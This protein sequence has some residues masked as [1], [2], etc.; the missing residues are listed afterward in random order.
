MIELR[1]SGE[2]YEYDVRGLLMAF[3]P[4]E[5]IEKK[6]YSCEYPLFDVLCTK[7]KGWE[8]SES[9]SVPPGAWRRQLLVEC[10]Q[11]QIR[12]TLHCRDEAGVSGI[13]RSFSGT[14][15]VEGA[16]RSAAKCALKR[17]L[18]G[19]LREDTHRELPWGTLTGIRPTKIAMGFLE[20]GR[21][22]AEIAA[23]MQKEYLVSPEKTALSLEIAEKERQ[24]LR[25]IDYENGFSLYVGIPFCPTICLYCSF[26]SYPFGRFAGQA[27][28]YVEA[29]ERELTATAEIF[30]GKQLNT[31][32]FGGGTPTTLLP[33]QLDR[34]LACVEKRF[35]CSGLREFTVEAGRPDSIGKEKLQVLRQHGI[36]RISINPQTMNQETLDR[37]G[38]RHT[39]EQVRDAFGLAR[40][41]G[42]DNIN[43]DLILGLPGEGLGDVRHTMEELKTLRPDSI[44]VHSLAVKRASR[45]SQC[46]EQ[47]AHMSM[48]NSDEAMAVASEGARILGLSPYY[49]YR[50]KNMTGNLEN[51]GFAV[52]GKEGIYN[53]LIMEEKQTIAACGA[54]S[55]SKRVDPDGRIERRENVKDVVQYIERIGEMIGR[56]RK[57][58][59]QLL[60]KER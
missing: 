35:D 33:E 31:V 26:S 16:D 8:T 52:P 19:L 60:M 57:L 1:L 59:G 13:S 20:A 42:F 56:K 58:F 28:A 2:N 55:I 4:N 23:Y 14:A 49:L 53:I 44:T 36:T 50:Q 51:V 9:D 29:L 6:A 54:G 39:V 3:Y 10:G 32:Y 45:L 18:Y 43:M 30:Q 38:R 12:V 17:V 37:I 11:E 15:D 46:R 21:S 40:Q 48:E 24:L 41:M 7:N 25:E 34:L 47:Y 5:E 27:D 22:K